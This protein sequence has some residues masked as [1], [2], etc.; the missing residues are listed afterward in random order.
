MGIKIL[1][2]GAAGFIGSH[3]VD[4]L[5]ASGFSVCGVDNFRTGRREN[6]AGALRHSRLVFRELDITEGRDFVRI[7]GEMHPDVVIHLAALVSVPESIANPALDDRLNFQATRIVVEAARE[8]GV[9]RIV[10]A[11]SA[12]VYGDP[13]DSVVGEDA[14]KKPLS[15][16]GAAK[17]GSEEHLLDSAQRYGFVA[18]CQRYFNV[19]G[20][21]QDP[22]SP[23]SGVISI[24]LD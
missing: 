8:H 10:F 22:R 2:T 14:A 21:R 19:Y 18:H 6:L 5:L 13:A 9:A 7:V 3:T 24:F 1:L 12:A 17:L 16:Y 4:Y 15:P 23:Y 11:S 20:S